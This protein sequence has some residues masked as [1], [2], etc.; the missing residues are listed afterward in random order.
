MNW[1]R[2]RATAGTTARASGRAAT[3]RLG[4]MLEPSEYLRDVYLRCLRTLRRNCGGWMGCSIDVSF[5][6]SSV[7]APVMLGGEVGLTA[8]RSTTTGHGCDTKGVYATE[9]PDAC[10]KESAEA[11]DSLSHSIL[12]RDIQHSAVVHVKGMACAP[13]PVFSVIPTKHYRRLCFY[14]LTTST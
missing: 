6:M 1:G 11:L 2:G 9:Q 14:H 8:L 7:A 5:A 13:V 10:L 12:R 3:M 4:N